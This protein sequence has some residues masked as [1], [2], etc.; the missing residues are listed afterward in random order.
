VKKK[1]NH[2]AR[3][4]GGRSKPVA[5]QTLATSASKK[6][7]ARIKINRRPKKKWAGTYVAHERMRGKKM[8][9]GKKMKKEERRG[10]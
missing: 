7:S 2:V 4:A 3:H 9:S 1:K 6:K 8:A 10:F 5:N